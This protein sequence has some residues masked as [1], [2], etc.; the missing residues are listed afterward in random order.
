M[1]NG[2]SMDETINWSWLH[3]DSMYQNSNVLCLDVKL[4][5]YWKCFI[6][7]QKDFFSLSE[8]GEKGLFIN[9]FA[10]KKHNRIQNAQFGDF[11]T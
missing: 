11:I 5:A 3:I 2:L 10:R 7:Y 4:N 6:I 1:C 9:H 8:A